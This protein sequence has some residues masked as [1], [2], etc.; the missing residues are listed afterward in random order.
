[1][2][3]FSICAGFA[4]SI[5]I[6]APVPVAGADR[7]TVGDPVL[8]STQISKKLRLEEALQRAL[9][10]NPR[11]AVA[12]GELGVADA[13][14]LQA[15][16]WPN[17]ELKLE[18]EGSDSASRE[19]ALL[20]SQ[21]L[22]LGGKRAARIEVADQARQLAQAQFALALATTR[23]QVIQA[24]ALALT[25][26]EQAHQAE[27]SL[28]LAEKALAATAKRVDAGTISPVEE[29][30]AQLA[31]TTARSQLRK[32]QGQLHS[33][34]LQLA[35]LWGSSTPDFTEVAGELDALPELPPLRALEQQLDTSPQLLLARQELARLK[36][37]A[38]LERTRR[39]PNVTLS[40]GAR[41][42][43]E[44]NETVPVIGVSMPIPLFDRN[45]GN[46]LEAQRRVE[47]A[48]DQL[49][50][51]RIQLRET[52][53]V[54]YSRLEVAEDE[55]NLIRNQILPA[56][57]SAYEASVKGF[58]LGKFSFLDVL[59]AQ[60]TLYQARTQYVE[61]LAEAHE[62]YASIE[63]IRGASDL[64]PDAASQ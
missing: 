38:Q 37:L 52:L 16:L 29:T 28:E 19:V 5:F 4:A 18:V 7:S 63:S 62:A 64:Q 56:A 42:I 40:A 25:V 12:R 61:A 39:I 53:G 48:Q 11:L 13:A 44:T 9:T 1:M 8:S 49:A 15:A 43:E 60:R 27:L 21:P 51:E 41:R 50:L 3:R 47:I 55:A 36:A 30:R 59:D 14:R 24:F 10:Q 34:R 31:A 32:A 26:Q 35:A 6:L 2:R 45:Q 57:E 20:L 46:V 33:T 22:E 23:A 54:A 58:E 17:P